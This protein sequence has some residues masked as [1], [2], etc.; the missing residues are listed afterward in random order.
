[1]PRRSSGVA[2]APPPAPVQSGNGSVMG[3]LGAT[4]ADGLAF[5]TGSAVAH[6]AVDAMLGP[7]VIQHDTV[8][9]PAPA[10]ASAPS[11]TSSEA[12]NACGNHSKALQDE[13]SLFYTY[14]RYPVFCGPYLEDLGCL[15]KHFLD[16]YCLNNYGSD[17]S[18]CQFYMDMLQECHRNSGTLSA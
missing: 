1:M 18:K 16:Q 6:R 14:F 2:R 11:M 12:R 9:S 7:R 3:G 15:L 8:A 5:G 4:I 13:I 17:I 10:A